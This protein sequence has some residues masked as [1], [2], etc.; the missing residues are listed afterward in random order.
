MIYVGNINL[1]KD[2]Y[3]ELPIKRK[4]LGLPF[5]EARKN[6]KMK[7]KVDFTVEKRD[8]EVNKTERPIL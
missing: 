5:K 4:I 2:S 3:F 6:L 8:G 7:Y 1:K